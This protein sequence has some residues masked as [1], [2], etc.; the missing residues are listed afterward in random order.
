MSIGTK[1]NCPLNP[2]AL[3]QCVFDTQKKEC[4]S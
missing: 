1:I 2:R 3:V 4:E